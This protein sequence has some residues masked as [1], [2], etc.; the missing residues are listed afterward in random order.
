VALRIGD[1]KVTYA[2]AGDSRIYHMSAGHLVQLTKDHSYVQ[3]MVDHGYYTQ[4]QA[5]NSASKNVITRAVG[6]TIKLQVPVATI[7][8]KSG[9]MFLLCSDGLSNELSAITMELILGSN[10]SVEDLV[11]TLIQTANANGGKDNITAIVIRIL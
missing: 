1:D 5:E 4:E 8:P 10:G 2:H 6:L 11:T 7:V 9:D 3:E